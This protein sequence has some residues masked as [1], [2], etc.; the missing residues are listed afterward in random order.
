MRVVGVEASSPMFDQGKD[1]PETP[2]REY[3]SYSATCN[4]RLRVCIH[5]SYLEDL[6]VLSTAQTLGDPPHQKP[7]D[8]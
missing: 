2:E 8:G 6:Q 5:K 3:L 7:A 4:L 1:Q